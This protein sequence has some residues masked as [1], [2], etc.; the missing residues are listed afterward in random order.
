MKDNAIVTKGLILKMG[1][2]ITIGAMLRAKKLNIWAQTTSKPVR[3]KNQ[4]VRLSIARN[5]GSLLYRGKIE[6]K[7]KSVSL[8]R[9]EPAWKAGTLPTE[10]LPQNYI[11]FS[12]PPTLC[13]KKMYFYNS[14]GFV[15]DCVG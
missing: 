9:V 14:Q 10:L 15:S 4:K 7:P 6:A 11:Y 12:S 13:Q 8:E 1:L 3:K 5:R 2:M